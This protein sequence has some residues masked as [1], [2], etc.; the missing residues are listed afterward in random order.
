VGCY[1]ARPALTYSA[2]G[3]PEGG[4]T[5]WADVQFSAHG[6]ARRPLLRSNLDR[7]SSW[8]IKDDTLIATFS[9]GL[10]GWRLR[11]TRVPQGWSGVA[12][13]LSDAYVVGRPPYQHPITLTHRSCADPA[14][15]ARVKTPVLSHL[16]LAGEVVQYEDT[17][18]LAYVRGP[19][20]IIVGLAEQLG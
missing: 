6:E 11:L 8:R 17:Y 5:T 19:E 16:E 3:G 2:M 15:A 9:D 4:D 7:N 13:Y 14:Q 12:K 20:G 1:V 18:R 10:V